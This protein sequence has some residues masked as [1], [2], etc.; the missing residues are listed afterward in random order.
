MKTRG[1]FTALAVLMCACAGYT[2]AGEKAV[3]PQVAKIM[4]EVSEARIRATIE[5]LVSFGTRNTMSNPD[6]PERGVGAA[7]QWIFKEMQSYSPRL[8]VRF[9]KYRVKKQG[10]RIF[11]DVD[12][13]NVIAVLPGTRM[14]ETQILIGAHYDSINLGRP[15]GNTPV[16][17]GTDAP[18]AEGAGGGGGF[19]RGAQMTPEEFERSANLPAP[20]ACDDGSGIGAMMELARVMSQY[21]FDKTL[22]FVAFAG[23]EQGL[24]GSNLLSAK[25]KKDNQAIE[26]VLNNDI[27]GTDVS[28]NGRAGNTTVNVYSDE[29]MDSPSQTL[30]RFAREIGE[31]YMPFFHVNTVFF[32]DRI[33]RGGDHTPFQLEGYAAVRISTPNEIYAN[34]HHATDLLENMSVPYTAKVARFNGVVAASL[35][36]APK[37]PLVTRVPGA[38]AGRGRAGGNAN[39]T[40]GAASGTG[41]GRGGRGRGGSASDGAVSAD[42]AGAAG[43]GGQGGGRGGDATDSAASAD[44]AGAAGGAGRGGQGGQAG[45]GGRGRGPMVSRGAGYDAVLQWRPN[46]SEEGIKGYAVLVRPTTA[47]YWEQEIYVG[48]VNS[49]TLKDVSIDDVRFGVRAIGLDGSESLATPYVNPPRQKT[50]IETVEER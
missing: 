47:P 29:I 44:A 14:P 9:D 33:G 46:G 50:V 11:K 39:A 27:I 19:G 18:P 4:D 15:A 48:K 10:Q 16:G 7:R 34:Q 37:A 1:R 25:M 12:L 20:G 45:Q 5:R 38:G 2:A 40:D 28:G 6:D 23:E 3:N 24:I 43:R 8:Q 22:V 42:A 26:A 21:E 32:Q 30:A 41:G 31:R 49:Y 13:W 36:L 35:A 17:P